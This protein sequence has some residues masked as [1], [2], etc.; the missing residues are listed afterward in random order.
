M[1]HFPLTMVLSLSPSLPPPALSLY[2][3]LSDWTSLKLF[4]LLFSLLTI[5]LRSTNAFDQFFA[6]L[7]L[8]LSCVLFYRCI[9]SSLLSSWV[10]SKLSTYLLCIPVDMSVKLLMTDNMCKRYFATNALDTISSLPSSS[11]PKPAYPCLPLVSTSNTAVYQS[12]SSFFQYRSRRFTSQKIPRR[13]LNRKSRLALK[14]DGIFQWTFLG[15]MRISTLC[16]W[17]CNRVMVG[18]FN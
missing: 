6:D 8:A 14:V 4:L 5:I 16:I 9:S 17:R 12:D 1:C 15:Q 2:L 13:Q 18:I 10:S 3:F 11:R 7:V